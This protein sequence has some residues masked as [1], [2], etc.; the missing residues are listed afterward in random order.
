MYSQSFFLTPLCPGILRANCLQAD[1]PKKN[2]SLPLPSEAA[3]VKSSKAGVQEPEGGK[4]ARQRVH[5][6]ANTHRKL[7]NVT[8]EAED[9]NKQQMRHLRGKD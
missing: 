7:G 9:K 2:D 8:V 3:A 6:H 5:P 1:E 4:Q